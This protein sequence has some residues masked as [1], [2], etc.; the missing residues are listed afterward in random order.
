LYFALASS[1]ADSTKTGCLHTRD[2]DATF[3][4][5]AK[6]DRQIK[7]QLQVCALNQDGNSWQRMKEDHTDL[8]AESR[9]QL[10][11]YQ[12]DRVEYKLNTLNY[13][14]SEFSHRKDNFE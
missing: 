2:E 13:R 8:L 10:T 7:G 11:S 9:K 5:W 3:I 4:Q 6:T 12:L 14:L 1:D